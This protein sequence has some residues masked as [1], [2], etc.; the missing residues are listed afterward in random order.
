[1][2]ASATKKRGTPPERVSFQTAY[3]PATQSFFQFG[4]LLARGEAQ[5]PLSQLWQ[6]KLHR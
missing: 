3:D 4:G 6:A 5:M 1:M 2:T